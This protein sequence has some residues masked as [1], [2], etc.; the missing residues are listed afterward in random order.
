MINVKMIVW[1]MGVLFFIEVGFFILCLFFVVYYNELDILVF[2]YFVVIIV[3]V[4]SIVVLVGKN[5]EKR[6]SCCDGYVIV[7]FVWVFFF[8]FGMFLFYLSGYIF[9]IMDVFFEIMLGF[10]IIGVSILDN[11]ELLLYGFLFW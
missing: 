5:V 11:I 7:I 1:I 10:I 6:I 8:L 3:G 2:L 4:G 9:I